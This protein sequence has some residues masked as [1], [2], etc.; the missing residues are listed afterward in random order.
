MG[1]DL[2]TLT[3]IHTALSIIALIVGVVVVVG[4]FVQGLSPLWTTLFLITA[5]ATSATG[6]LFPFNGVLPSHIVGGIALLVLVL[7]LL[8]RFVC[9]LGGPWRWIYPVGLV[10]SFYLLV[11][12][13]IAQ[14]FAKVAF[15]YKAA[16]TQ[17]E[18]P[19]LLAQL[20]ALALVVGLAIAA[21]RM[22]RQGGGLR[23]AT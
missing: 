23:T 12:V 20:V 5:I 7:V 11:F 17:T 6:F 19:F 14:A 9:R 18:L 1:I 8:A 22:A 16:P 2:A 13:A 21:A 4:L 15:L 3:V 10:I